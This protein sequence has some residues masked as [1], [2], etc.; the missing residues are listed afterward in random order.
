MITLIWPTVRPLIAYQNASRWVGLAT[1]ASQLEIWFGVNSDAD[2][3]ILIDAETV[4][5][6][7]FC[8]RF[9]LFRDARPG[10]T[11]T[12]TQMTLQVCQRTGDDSDIVVLAS[13]DFDC[14]PG[15]DEH[16]RNQYAFG[17]SGALIANDKYAQSTNI[18]PLPILSVACLKRL[19]GIVYSPFYSH[20][21]SDQEFFDVCVEL[22][23]IKNLRG[24][25]APR[26]T[27]Q[28]WT[29]NSARQRDKF[30]ERNTT[31][32]DRD[33]ATYERRK[34]MPVEEKLKLPD[35]WLQ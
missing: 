17:W 26:F 25:D 29:F 34:K 13:D 8:P 21:F 19:N 20:F 31:W 32:W 5:P 35:W 3:K 18:I 4:K 27:H 22:K 30:D 2:R 16:L 11:D 1:D 33:K 9:C 10:I 15:W 6:L 24:T 14:S 12:V 23:L 28:H 7:S